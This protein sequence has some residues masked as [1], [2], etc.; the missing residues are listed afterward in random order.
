MHKTDK[1]NIGLLFCHYFS[2]LFLAKPGLFTRNFRAFY[3]TS[4][5][6]LIGNQCIKLLFQ[7]F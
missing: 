7:K 6:K 4:I 3:M 1:I 5:G 2:S